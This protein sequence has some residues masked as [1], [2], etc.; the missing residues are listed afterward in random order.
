MAS[1]LQK[2]LMGEIVQLVDELINQRETIEGHALTSAFVPLF[3]QLRS[4]LHDAVTP[5]EPASSV[6]ERDRL[7]A[8]LERLDGEFDHEVRALCALLDA[9]AVDD[10]ERARRYR[11]C[12]EALFP[13]GARLVSTSLRNQA[14]QAPRLRALREAPELAETL[15]I[16]ING[17]TLEI[18]LARLINAAE[19]LAEPLR[20]LATSQQSGKG[21]PR[22]RK[23]ALQSRFIG[24]IG[25]L[26]SL[27][28]L[29]EWPEDDIESVFGPLDRMLDGR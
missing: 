25:Q 12:K 18:R 27:T 28:E 22:H 24:L 23:I 1:P 26:R 5:A 16:S 20:A 9:L 15:A 11:M 7:R 17:E 10:P 8:E 2:L 13:R 29:A 21:Q 3:E 14:G 6:T 4:D 19:G